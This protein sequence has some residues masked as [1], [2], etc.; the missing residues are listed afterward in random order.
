MGQDVAKVF[1]PFQQSWWIKGVVDEN[2]V[3]ISVH[4]SEIPKPACKYYGIRIPASQVPEDG[5]HLRSGVT[6]QGVE[7]L[8][9]VS[10]PIL[11]PQSS[12]Q[13]LHA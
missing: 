11:L 2:V 9:S 6:L 8:A 3:V 5:N 10:A 1:L 7:V 4:S 13:P 12:S